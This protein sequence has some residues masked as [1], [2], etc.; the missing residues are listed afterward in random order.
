MSDERLA[1]ARARAARYEGNWPDDSVYGDVVHLL[2]ALDTAT[3]R[4]AELERLRDDL[5]DAAGDNADDNAALRRQVT[6]LADE[7]DDL[8]RQLAESRRTSE[9]PARAEHTDVEAHNAKLRKEL[10]EANRMLRI[11]GRE[12]ES[13]AAK[14]GKARR[15]NEELARAERPAGLTV[16]EALRRVCEALKRYGDG[17]LSYQC[18]IYEDGT[19]NTMPLAGELSET[20]YQFVSPSNFAA[21]VECQ[22]AEPPKVRTRRFT[23]THK[24]SGEWREGVLHP[25]GASIFFDEAGTIRDSADKHQGGAERDHD[26]IQW[27]DPE[28]E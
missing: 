15:V 13:L 7:T 19:A 14:L 10:A 11:L 24:L 16:E 21:W 1:K 27:L 28:G 12:G 26:N 25:N 20:A 18:V 4:V 2:A 22:L 6:E 8:R 9:Q 17:K 3:A 5:A 23:C